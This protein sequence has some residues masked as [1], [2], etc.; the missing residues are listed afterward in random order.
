MIELFS[1]YD[2]EGFLRDSEE[3]GLTDN[4]LLDYRIWLEEI[5]SAQGRDVSSFIGDVFSIGFNFVGSDEESYTEATFIIESI[6]RKNGDLYIQGGG[7]RFNVSLEIRSF[8]E[9][10]EKF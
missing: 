10:L 6:F 1:E 3:N 4:Y 5:E 2:K 8:Q 7:F 9:L